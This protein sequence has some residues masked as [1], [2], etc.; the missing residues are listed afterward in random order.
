MCYKHFYSSHF[1]N[2]GWKFDTEPKEE[3]ASAQKNWK[4]S[5]RKQGSQ[6]TTGSGSKEI[7]RCLW[8]GQSVWTRWEYLL[9]TIVQNVHLHVYHRTC[10]YILKKLFQE[11][12]S[13]SL[14]SGHEILII[15]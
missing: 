1:L 9:N 13:W 2:R 5:G 15:D 14:S 7:E 6:E 11:N 10:M 4:C 8:K 3:S 12:W